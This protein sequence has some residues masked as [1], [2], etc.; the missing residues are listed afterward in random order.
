MR[1]HS[2][3]VAGSSSQDRR[4]QYESKEVSDSTVETFE[5]FTDAAAA[6]AAHCDLLASLFNRGACEA[7]RVSRGSVIIDAQVPREHAA[8][9]AQELRSARVAAACCTRECARLA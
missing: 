1:S 3:I 8:S 2:V 9:I 6:R 4:Q 7:P 5:L